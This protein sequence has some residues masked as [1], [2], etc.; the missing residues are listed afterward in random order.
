MFSALSLNL[1]ELRM[2]N[3]NDCHVTEGTPP[4]SSPTQTQQYGLIPITLLE[5]KE[6]LKHPTTSTFTA[7]KMGTANITAPT[8]PLPANFLPNIPNAALQASHK[9]RSFSAFAL[10]ASTGWLLT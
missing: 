7:F 1:L 10:N 9:A 6:N 8:Q 2:H 5:N 4:G 3:Y